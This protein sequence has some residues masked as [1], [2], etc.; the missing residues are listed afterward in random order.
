MTSSTWSAWV[1]TTESASNTFSARADWQPPA[2]GTS[3]VA[4]SAGG[5]GG[6]I[7]QGG[8]YYL[9]ANVADGGNPASGTASVN[10]NAGTLT[11]GSTAAPLTAGSYT[12][13]GI[14]YGYRS[15]LLTANAALAA[16]SYATTVSVADQA[17]NT[18]AALTGPAV[19]ADNSQPAGADVQTANGGAVASRADA[20]DTVTYTFTEPPDPYSILA[21]WD[22]SAVAASVAIID[23]K[24]RD[25]IQ[26]WNAGATAQ[27]PLGSVDL[28]G[29]FVS[30]TAGFNATMVLS[31]ST[32][33]L[34]LGTQQIGTVRTE[35]TPYVVTWSP[36]TLAGTNDRAGNALLG[37]LVNESGSTDGE[38]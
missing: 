26:I 6:F 16:G 8:G 1:A 17:G 22:G 25:E 14:A 34:T 29:D 2:L 5:T 12:V 15:A 21:G 19:T 38:F 13:Q 20:G 4:K 31:G 23:A 32:I 7:H 36:A 37:T 33:T 3:I 11:T 28:K 9:Y 35:P 10:G 18:A 24:K 27:L 30:V